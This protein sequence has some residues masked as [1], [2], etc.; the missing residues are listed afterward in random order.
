MPD[1]QHVSLTRRVRT[2]DRPESVTSCAWFLL[3]CKLDD[4]IRIMWAFLQMR[5]EKRQIKLG[6]GLKYQLPSFDM[7]SCPAPGL[8]PC[9]ANLEA[10]L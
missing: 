10:S 9:I 2:S 5:R 6:N 4:E 1:S 8:S 7:Q 3:V